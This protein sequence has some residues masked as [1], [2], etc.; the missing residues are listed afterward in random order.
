MSRNS[1]LA[2]VRLSNCGCAGMRVAALAH[3]DVQVVAEQWPCNASGRCTLV[4]IV[5]CHDAGQRQ[6]L[7][8][9]CGSLRART[10]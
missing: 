10:H 9:G 3:R 6:T 5:A 7:A 1:V 2:F 4:H 8:A